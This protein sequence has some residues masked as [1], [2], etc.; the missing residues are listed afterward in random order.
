MNAKLSVNDTALRAALVER[1][2]QCSDDASCI[3]LLRIAAGEA[4]AGPDLLQDI[5][6]HFTALGLHFEAERSFTRA[7]QAQPRNPAYLYNHATALIALGRLEDAEAAFDEVIELNPADSDACY[8]R[9]TLRKQTPQR[10]HVVQLE[11]CLQQLSP[12]ALGDVALGYALAKELEDLGEHRRSFAAIKRAAQARRRQLA[13]RVEDDVDTM[14]VIADVFDQ[15]FFTSSHGGH[16]DS[17]PLFIVGL[18][19][20]GSTLVDRILSSHELVSSRGERSDL[21]LAVMQVTKPAASKHEL[22]RHSAH[23][24]LGVLGARYAAHLDAAQAEGARAARVQIDKTPSNFLYLGLIAA[25]LPRARIVHVRRRPMDACYAIYK[26]LFRMAY[27]YS[28][29]LEDLGHYWLAYDAL[30]AH[31]RAMLPAETLLEIDYEDLVANQEQVS[32]R[33]VAHAGLEWQDACLAFERNAQSSLTASAAQVR[34][35]MYRSSVGL[36]KRYREELAPLCTLLYDAGVDI[37]A[38]PD[39][40]HA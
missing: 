4:D 12:T 20:S 7:L 19:R 27:P 31:W 23:A 32:R 15:N 17:R 24:D 18:P 10:N 30:M 22:V 3:A 6:Q 2:K 14:R 1:L 38:T 29:A 33:L 8:N 21:A 5:G 13:Y 11:R 37:D 34:Q 40:H 9:A 35:P 16:P 28:Y 36:W 25:S 39:G 26:T